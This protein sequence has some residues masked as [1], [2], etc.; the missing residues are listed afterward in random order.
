[1]KELIAIIKKNELEQKMTREQNEIFENLEE[2]ILL[3]KDNTI[4]FSNQ[5][6]KNIFKDI[7][8]IGDHD[9]VTDAILDMKVFKLFEH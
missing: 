1:M 5:I 9:E 2:G 7:N 8:V 4:N 3:L 6:F